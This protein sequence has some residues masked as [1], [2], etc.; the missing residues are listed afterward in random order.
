[1]VDKTQVNLPNISTKGLLLSPAILSK[2]LAESLMTD[3]RV[4]VLGTIGIFGFAF[5]P[6]LI[7]MKMDPR[8]I[9]RASKRALYV[10][11]LSVAAPLVVAH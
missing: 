11:L 7:G 8:M 1:M 2:D 3:G 9:F 5:F 4:Q 10:G 6:F